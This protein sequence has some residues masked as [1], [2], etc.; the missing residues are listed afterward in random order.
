MAKVE[1][2]SINFKLP[3]PLVEALRA[4]A[5]ERKTT[6]TD[7]VIQGLDHVLG[8]V[9]GMESDVKTHLHQLE[10]ELKQMANGIESR[11][12][13][14]LGQHQE[15]LSSLEQK[16]EAVTTKLAQLEGA[17]LA[18][19]R[20]KNSS[21]RQGYPYHSSVPQSVELQPF[22]PEN[23]AKRLGVTTAT[24]IRERKNKS[25]SEFESWCRNRDPSGTAWSYQDN[26]LY[27]PFK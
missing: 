13:N 15:Q 10:A 23:L 18:G 11:V 24:L 5:R 14:E 12:D 4:A 20:Y 21:R 1:R 25:Q 16:L 3:K 6:A 9:D 7:L 22:P 27:H 26:G 19:Q 8:A 2:E 17:L